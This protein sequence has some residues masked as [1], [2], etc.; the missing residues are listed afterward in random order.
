[1]AEHGKPEV[2]KHAGDSHLPAAER[3]FAGNGTLCPVMVAASI[4]KERPAPS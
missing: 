4:L 1:M 3:P 2:R